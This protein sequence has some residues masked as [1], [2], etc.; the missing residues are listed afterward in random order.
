MADLAFLIGKKIREIRK[1]KGLR[2][3]DVEA[4]GISY[5]YFQKIETGKANVTLK[6][7]EKIANALEID[8]TEFFDFPE[9]KSSEFVKLVAAVNEI[10]KTI[11]ERKAKKLN[12]LIREILR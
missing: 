6:T 10:I 1:R 2:Q 7:L 4:L 5:K 12:V 3:E 8:P 11:D 9:R